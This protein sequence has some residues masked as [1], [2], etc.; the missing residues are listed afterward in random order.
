MTTERPAAPQQ[1]PRRP[2]LMDPAGAPHSGFA[3]P[4]V[5]QAAQPPPEPLFTPSILAAPAPP[6]QEVAES[7]FGP[8]SEVVRLSVRAAAARLDLV[9]PDRC[10]IAEVLEAVLQLSP[11]AL[12]EQAIAHGGWTLRGADGRDLPSAAT[13]LDLG[14]A[15]GSTLLLLGLD[16]AAIAPVYDDVADA[17]AD[18]VAGDPSAWP[19]GAGRAVA[20][21]AA[22]VFAAVGLAALLLAGPP[23]PPVALT[24]AAA[25]VAAQLAAGLL[26]RGTGDDGAALTLAVISV[27]TG[28]AAAAVATGGPA[29]LAGLG[30]PQLLLGAAGALLCAT[31]AA[32][33]VGSRRVPMVALVAGA[34]VVGA[35]AACAVLFDL[36]PAGAAAIVAGLCL[37]LLPVVPSAAMRMA[38]FAIPPLPAGVDQAHADEGG[39]DPVAVAARTRTAVG[40]LTALVQGLSWPALGAALVLASAGDVTAQVLAGVTAAALLLRARLF[41]TIGQRLPLLVAGLGAVV[42]V[43]IGVAMDMSGAAALWMAAPAALGVLGSLAL[44]MRRGPVSPAMRRTGEILDVLLA[45]AMV[46]LVAAVLGLFGVVR[47]LGG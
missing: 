37:A 24:L 18:T 41:V 47:G 44:A 33:V 16:T 7:A 38:R 14:I 30:A 34:V 19:P 11:P 31:T 1:R 12:R 32:L 6:A 10:T 40:H 15:D 20:L 9:L 29:R 36:P 8:V 23:W 13:L 39:V 22:G 35:G 45:V 5:H 21:G 43:L 17:V 4:T 28:A 42:A 46:P 26:S 3:P 25:T 2:L 27:A